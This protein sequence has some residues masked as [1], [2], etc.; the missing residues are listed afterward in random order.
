MGVAF[1]SAKRAGFEHRRD[2]AKEAE[3]N[4][5]NLFSA[6][7]E[8]K[9]ALFRCELTQTDLLL[10]LGQMVLVSSTGDGRLSVLLTN[11]IVGRVLPQEAVRLQPTLNRCP[12]QMIPAR[13]VK[14]PK[15]GR[16]FSIQI[17]PLSGN[18]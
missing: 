9:T 18:D 2:S 6:L 14:V 11:R 7:P 4:D 13:V 10:Q 5:P 12:A 15:L 16:R 17:E 1:I 8:A 3:L